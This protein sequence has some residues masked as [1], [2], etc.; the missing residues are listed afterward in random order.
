MI[1]LDQKIIPYRS[2]NIDD[3]KKNDWREL[4]L[5]VKNQLIVNR[6]NYYFHDKPYAQRRLEP[7]AKHEAILQTQQA[8]NCLEHQKCKFAAYCTQKIERYNKLVFEK[9]TNLL[10]TCISGKQLVILCSTK[11]KRGT[12]GYDTSS[13]INSLELSYQ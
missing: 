4:K 5:G 12:F 1:E 3:W 11:T 8:P 7:E 2:H 10:R 6:L 9:Q 13:E